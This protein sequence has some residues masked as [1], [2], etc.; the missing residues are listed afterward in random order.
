MAITKV[1]G[2]WPEV[3]DEAVVTTTMI[4]DR[5]VT[6]AKLEYP[7][8]DVTLTYLAAINK[9]RHFPHSSTWPGGHEVLTYDSFTDKAVE[10]QLRDQSCAVGRGDG[11]DDEYVID[12]DSGK[13]T[14]DFFMYKVVS[15]TQTTLA[16]ESIDIGTNH[17]YLCKLSISGST[18]KGY[19]DDMT[20]EKISATDTDLTSGY[21][22]FRFKSDYHA[23]SGLDTFLR[24]P[25]SPLPK[26]LAVIEVE[27]TG[28]GT[29]ED[30]IRPQLPQDLRDPKELG[31]NINK[32]QINLKSITWGAIDYKGGNT[33]IIAIYKHG[34]DYLDPKRFEDVLAIAKN[35]WKVPS[36]VQEAEE[37][38]KELKKANP[39]MIAGKHSI[40]YHLLG[41][42]NV[43]PCSVADFYHGN[44]IEDNK[45]KGVP[46]WE[47]RRTLLRWKDRLEKAR[48]NAELK[49]KH[50]K[51]LE[52]CLKR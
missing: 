13:S 27:V 48:I 19:R 2:A 24:A 34:A 51:K 9:I 33:M 38:W 14:E 47:L 42:E 29:E 5:A 18:I 10:I 12:L 49:E 26:P 35:K 16:S 37:I 17:I 8:E 21:F 32:P 50:M 15:G 6:R 7:T 31:L 52:E 46:E 41:D 11:V 4:H 23:L 1:V 3:I 44:M 45:I 43:E 36:N 40:A 30:P 39:D 28:K 20:T 22:G 25:S